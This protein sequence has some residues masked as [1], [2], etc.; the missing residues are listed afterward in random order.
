MLENLVKIVYLCFNFNA[1]PMHP[2]IGFVHLKHQ[3]FSARALFCLNSLGKVNAQ[4][5]IYIWAVAGLLTGST[6][7]LLVSACTTVCEPLTYLP[8][9]VNAH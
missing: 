4:L 1:C 3:N 6:I 2:P 5:L 7:S 9:S 8:N